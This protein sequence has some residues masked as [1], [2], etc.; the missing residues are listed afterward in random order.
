MLMLGQCYL[1]RRFPLD[2]LYIYDMV[3]YECCQLDCD[4][5]LVIPYDT[6]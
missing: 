3:A 2:R 1:G 6:S 4:E 5:S